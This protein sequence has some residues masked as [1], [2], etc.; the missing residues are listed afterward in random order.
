MLEALCEYSHRYGA[1]PEFVL[2]G[3]GNTS[4]KDENNLWI[5]GSGSS[6]STIRPEQFVKMDRE[7]LALMMTKIYPPMRMSAKPPF[8]PT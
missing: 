1:D 7:K 5:K 6:L 2:A 3:G 4:Y 8:S